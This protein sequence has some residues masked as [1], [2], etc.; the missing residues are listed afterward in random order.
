MTPN[1]STDNRQFLSISALQGEAWEAWN[2]SYYAEDR[3]TYRSVSLDLYRQDVHERIN[4]LFGR[5]DQQNALLDDLLSRA[6][7]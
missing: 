7:S 4:D 1:H 5:L 3:E 2:A 6:A